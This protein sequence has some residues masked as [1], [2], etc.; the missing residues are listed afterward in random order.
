[1]EVNGGTVRSGPTRAFLSSPE[2]QL[3]GAVSKRLR[4]SFS[5]KKALKVEWVCG[6]AGEER[7]TED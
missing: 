5:K 1:M 3:K 4:S 6:G 7:D 2:T